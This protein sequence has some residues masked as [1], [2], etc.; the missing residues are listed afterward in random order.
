VAGL[1]PYVILS[2]RHPWLRMAAEHNRWNASPALWFFAMLGLPALLCTF[3]FFL[4]CRNQSPTDYLLRC[5]FGV[6]LV[7]IFVPW[8][9]WS[10]HLLDGFYYATGLLLV[11]RGMDS[12]TIKRLLT[13][14]M[15]WARTFVYTVVVL[16]VASHGMYMMQAAMAGRIAQGPLAAVASKPEIAV[17][18]WL[19]QNA[20]P[21]ELV[22]APSEDAGWYATIPMHSF[23][24]HWL[25]SLTFTEQ[26]RL[27]HQ[28]YRGQFDRAAADAFLR[29]YGVRYA[30]VPDGSPAARY[31]SPPTQATHIGNLTI[32][33]IPSA[34]MR[35]F[36]TAVLE[37]TFR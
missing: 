25:F 37:R 18:A 14:S 7:G 8:V 33:Q 27:S 16:S 36:S 20:D 22:L 15:T 3:T 23:A 26:T 9:P 28:F 32:Y 6:V 2:L 19:K 12:V 4:P 1:A 21:R 10:Q 11:R 17:R 5:W 31:F 24:S 30:V 35:P 13:G 34:A 29:E